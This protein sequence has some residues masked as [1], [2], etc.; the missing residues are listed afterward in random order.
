[1]PQG[2]Q[3]HSTAETMDP[4][5]RRSRLM[6]MEALA[7]LLTQKDFYDISIQEIAAEANPI[8]RCA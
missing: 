7:K 4:R 6:L 3:T 1:M 8:D 2:L 5:I